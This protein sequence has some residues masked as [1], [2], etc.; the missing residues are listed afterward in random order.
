MGAF[1]LLLV[2][3]VGLSL[4][5]GARS[6]QQVVSGL[7]APQ[8]ALAYQEA[9]QRYGVL[10]REGA[11]PVLRTECAQQA[12]FLRLFPECDAACEALT[13]KDVPGPTR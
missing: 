4:L 9:L 2:L 6:E 12:H 1:L 7:P 3:A 10:C 5:W 11:A 13:D 8:R